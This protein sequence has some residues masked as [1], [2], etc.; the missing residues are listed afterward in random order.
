MGLPLVMRPLAS[1]PRALPPFVPPS[2]ARRGR[3]N[4]APLCLQ[5]RVGDELRQ[6]LTGK[7]TLT[8]LSNDDLDDAKMPSVK[9]SCEQKEWL[10]FFEQSVKGG[11][12]PLQRTMFSFIE[13]A[14]A[15]WGG[16][17]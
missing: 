16:G 12:S 7:M 11:W 10:K 17:Q 15:H 4:F 1:H 6:I 5:V 14:K 3:G 13:Q 8:E 9:C 2:C